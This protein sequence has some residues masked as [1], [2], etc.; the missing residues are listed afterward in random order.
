MNEIELATQEIVKEKIKNFSNKNRILKNEDKKA[1]FPAK[2]ILSKEEI[3][4]LPT[5]VKK[6]IDNSIIIGES[7][8]TA[9]VIG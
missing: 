8:S 3:E 4:K 5:W 6:D 9:C 7:K 1:N 2:D